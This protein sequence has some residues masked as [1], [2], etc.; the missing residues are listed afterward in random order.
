MKFLHFL[1]ILPFAAVAVWA[2]CCAASSTD[3]ISFAPW[4]EYFVNP[5]LVL[6]CATIFGYLMGRIG[7][8]FGY[9]VVRRDLRAQRR[10]NQALN[11]EHVKLNET[12][13]G[14]KQ[15]LVGLQ[16]KAKQNQPETAHAGN[17][18]DAFKG[19]KKGK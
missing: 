9:S 14:L 15:D 8:W 19:T 11:K 13:T 16:E 4:K 18:W 7:A 10:T 3:G 1:I 6:A 2:I 12:V 5:H 17:W